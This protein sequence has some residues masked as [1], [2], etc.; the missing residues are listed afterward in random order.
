MKTYFLLNPAHPLKK[1][2]YT[3]LSDLGKIGIVN[4]GDENTTEKLV[5]TAVRNGYE[6]IIVVGGDGTLN[7]TIT[8]IIKL[9]ANEKIAVG[10]LPAGTCNDF[11]NAAGIKHLTKSAINGIISDT[12]PKKIDIGLMN[13]EYFINNS[14]FGRS[15]ETFVNKSSSFKTLLSLKPIRLTA[16]WNDGQIKG[17]FLML[18]VCNAPYFSGGFHFSKKLKTNDGMLDV[19]F[20][21]PV[22]KINLVL[23]FAKGKFGLPLADS[24][25]TYIKTNRIEVTTENRVFPRVDGEPPKSKGATKISFEIAKEK[26]NFLMMN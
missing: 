16:E 19:Y 1:Y 24:D 25:I 20:T 17:N 13:G 23:K 5:D 4:I 26:I 9:G 14:G 12:H 11:A 2:Y 18:L 15:Y 10:I 6:R 7:R 21:K 8:K 22:S 3:L